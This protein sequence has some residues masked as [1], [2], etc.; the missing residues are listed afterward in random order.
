MYTGKW[1]S[2]YQNY[3]KR[4]GKERQKEEKRKWKSTLSGRAHA[5][6]C[7]IQGKQKTHPELKVAITFE[8][9]ENLLV[10][11]KGKCQIT[12]CDLDFA[13]DGK[14]NP[15]APSIDQILPGKGYTRK[16]IQVVALWYNRMKSTLTDKEARKILKN[17]AKINLR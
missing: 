12:G 3:H 17:W 8:D 16:N 14:R 11:C 13:W 7:T 6:W 2:Q 9:I 4:G 15:Y 10:A 5:L 1:P